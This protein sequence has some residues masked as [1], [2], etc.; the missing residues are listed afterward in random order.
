MSPFIVFCFAFCVLWVV[1]KVSSLKENIRC[2]CEK[3][4][5]WAIVWMKELIFLQNI[6]TVQLPAILFKVS[7]FLKERWHSHTLDK[8]YLTYSRF[9]IWNIRSVQ[10]IFEH[11][12]LDITNS[13]WT[14]GVMDA[15]MSKFMI[16]IL[17]L[18]LIIYLQISLVWMAV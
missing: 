15:T 5:S 4:I 6:A 17:Y 10:W 12:R 7:R 2:L 9:I 18:W 11:H 8:Q 13:F 3:S 14:V 16:V 1:K